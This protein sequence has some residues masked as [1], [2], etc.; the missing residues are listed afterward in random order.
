MARLNTKNLKK[1]LIKVGRFVSPASPL[2]LFS[3]LYL[4]GSS[5]TLHLKATNG[6]GGVDLNTGMA[7]ETNLNSIVEF[8]KFNAI[9][10]RATE[11]E[12]DVTE[13]DNYVSIRFGG[14]SVKLPV[15]SLTWPIPLPVPDEGTV[16]SKDDFVRC[17]TDIAFM[18][19][20]EEA[21]YAQCQRLFSE[22]GQL[23]FLGNTG[24]SWAGAWCP[25][26]GAVA[27]AC[28]P[29]ETMHGAVG[30]F[31]DS[32]SPVTICHNENV[33]R[34][35]CGDAVI[36]CPLVSTG[37]MP[38]TRQQFSRV[39]ATA[40]EWEINREELIS[41]LELAGVFVTKEVTGIWLQ[42]N[43]DT[44]EATFTGV[45]DYDQSPNFNVDGR[46]A[47]VINATCQGNP[48]YINQRRLKSIIAPISDETITMLVT[49]TGVIVRS[50]GYMAGLAQLAPPQ[51]K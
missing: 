49:Q 17:A 47:A 33:V 48:V 3:K 14:A 36:T 31:G 27:N 29:F 45:S 26:Q 34:L 24:H 42:P 28:V 37:K 50:E 7:C 5:G 11:E 13:R 22:D 15:Y 10:S 43:G 23:S 20:Y 32:V 1:A 30:C 18:G 39:L 46:C 8:R 19:S 9:A 16:V 44:L 35:S 25:Y 38:M 12:I 41:F 6:F 51:N 21:H 4:D 2:E 40:V